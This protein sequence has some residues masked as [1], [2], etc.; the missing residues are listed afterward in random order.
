MVVLFC[1]VITSACQ[2]TL[3]YVHTLLLNIVFY[4]GHLLKI[5][6]ALNPK[7]QQHHLLSPAPRSTFQHGPLS[8]F[9][10]PDIFV[11]TQ[12]VINDH[13]SH[14]SISKNESKVN[15]IE[16]Y[17]VILASTPASPVLV[18]SIRFF[19]RAALR[20]ADQTGR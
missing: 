1:R 11:G 10:V 4:W 12:R 13:C 7:P 9:F 6:L 8:L 20:I 16:R 18:R 14:L 17:Q 3:E 5:S 15:D 19:N 2:N